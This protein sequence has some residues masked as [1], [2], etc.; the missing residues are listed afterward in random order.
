MKPVCACISI[1]LLGIVL[2][3]CF[4]FPGDPPFKVTVTNRTSEEIIV[5]L[6]VYPPQEEISEFIQYY[7]V[8]KVP[9]GK[10]ISNTLA[11]EVRGP[12]KFKIIAEKNMG[13]EVYSNHTILP[14]SVLEAEAVIYVRTFTR[15]EFF[16]MRN[17]VTI[18]SP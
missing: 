2:T 13:Q 12:S 10:T 9:P 15:S 8:G 6:G 14:W 4:L 3:S 5:Y 16:G 11:V 17:H 1:L 7:I 18:T